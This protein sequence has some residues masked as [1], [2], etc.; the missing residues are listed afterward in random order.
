MA[1]T[2]RRQAA[3]L[4]ADKHNDRDASKADGQPSINPSSVAK[5]SKAGRTTGSSSTKAKMS[6]RARVEKASTAG[7]RTGKTTVKY[8]RKADFRIGMKGYLPN[9]LPDTGNELFIPGYVRTF[10]NPSGKETVEESPTAQ[11]VRKSNKAGIQVE[12]SIQKKAADTKKT[13]ES[14][15]LPNPKHIPKNEDDAELNAQKSDA[16]EIPD[17]TMPT[18]TNEIHDIWDRARHDNWKFDSQLS[19]N[20]DWRIYETLMPAI[21]LASL[22]LIRPEYQS[23]WAT[24]LYAHCG[25]DDKHSARNTSDVKVAMSPKLYKDME[26]RLWDIAK[27]TQFRFAPLDATKGQWAHTEIISRRNSNDCQGN[28]SGPSYVT[29]LH[30]DFMYIPWPNRSPPAWKESSTCAKL[31]FLF[32]FAVKLGG[33]LVELLWMDRCQREHGEEGTIRRP[34]ISVGNTRYPSMSEAFESFVLG[35]RLHVIDKLPSPFSP[36]GLMVTAVDYVASFVD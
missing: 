30:E 13:A 7:K 25:S 24:I 10:A 14:V 5:A 20:Q 31:R 36:K 6:P 18:L 32:L 4:A 12:E 2:T 27:N 19:H 29:T 15:H 35:G 22:W 28:T 26:K 17:A 3:Q 11:S 21:R 8:D 23:F 9:G 16:L 34:C 33:Q 1:P